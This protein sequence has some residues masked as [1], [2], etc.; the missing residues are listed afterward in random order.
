MPNL[1]NARV[2]LKFNNSFLLQKSFSSL[3]SIFIL[4]LFTVYELN[5]WP[6]NPTKNFPLKNCLFRIVKL[7]RTKF[8][9][10][11]S[12]NFGNDFARN[13]VISSVEVVMKVTYM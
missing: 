8:D 5:N 13:I 10:E 4:N 2:I 11:G 7:E 12:W 9:Q 3:C 1:V 6:L